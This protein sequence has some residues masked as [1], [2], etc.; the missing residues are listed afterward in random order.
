MPVNDGK[1]APVFYEEDFA[2]GRRRRNIDQEVLA[3]LIK[4]SGGPVGSSALYFMQW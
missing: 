4:S 1:V 3:Q 2:C